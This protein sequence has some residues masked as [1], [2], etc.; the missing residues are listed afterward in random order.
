MNSLNERLIN[1]IGSEAS[2]DMETLKEIADALIAE[3]V[4]I[5]VRCGEC[6]RWVPEDS[7]KEYGLC[8]GFAT[9]RGIWRRADGFCDRGVRKEES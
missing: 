2:A 4:T 1:I 9:R 5:P 8:H 3:G 7:R 6:K